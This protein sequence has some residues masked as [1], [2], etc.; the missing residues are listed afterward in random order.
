[1]NKSLTKLFGE[2]SER[3]ET[4]PVLP[5]NSQVN[6]SSWE[7]RYCMGCFYCWE[8]SNGKILRI[9]RINQIEI[10]FDNKNI[11][12][13]KSLKEAFNIAIKYMKNH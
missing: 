11:G 12:T 6:P 13:T 2:T 10:L 8:N 4:T 9:E 1:M 7:Q 3:K 5:L